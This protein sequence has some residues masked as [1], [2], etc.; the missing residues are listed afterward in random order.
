[1]PILSVAKTL[2]IRC[3]SFAIDEIS[4]PKQKA[5]TAVNKVT[6]TELV[7][8]VNTLGV[9]PLGSTYITGLLLQ[10]ANMFVPAAPVP[11]SA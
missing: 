9:S 2:I 1:M 10:Y 11:V 8:A 6:I 5:V 4:R 3:N 7:I